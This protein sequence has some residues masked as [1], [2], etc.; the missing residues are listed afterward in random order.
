MLLDNTWSCSYRPT[1]LV[2]LIALREHGDHLGRPLWQCSPA[3]ACG[4]H[5]QAGR[6]SRILPAERARS[7]RCALV[8]AHAPDAPPRDHAFLSQPP[9]AVPSLTPHAPLQP[10]RREAWAMQPSRCPRAARL[11]PQRVDLEHTL[12][13]LDR[14]CHVP[15][16]A[17][18]WS[19]PPAPR[20]PAWS[21]PAP[22]PPETA[23]SLSA[24]PFSGAD[25]PC[26]GPDPLAPCAHERHAPSPAP[27]PGRPT[28]GAPPPGGGSSRLAGASRR[29]ATTRAVPARHTR[30]PGR[31]AAA[32]G[33]PPPA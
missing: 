33:V 23:S 13:A 12:P 19:Q 18:G 3:G 25:G 7:H 32:R 26:A 17:A 24:C 1:F 15:P 29:H 22:H 11:G 4:P 20:A 2:A 28:P 14:A 10:P 27:R 8:C 9:P 6:P 5:L 21:T 30:P 31:D 16:T